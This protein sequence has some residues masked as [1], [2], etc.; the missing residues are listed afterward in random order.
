MD[1]HLLKSLF[2]LCAIVALERN[3]PET[4]LHTSD[5]IFDWNKGVAEGGVD[6]IEYNLAQNV[7]LIVDVYR[8][9]SNL[10]QN[11][12]GHL[13]LSVFLY[14]EREDVSDRI[15]THH[16][17]IAIPGRAPPQKTILW[18]RGNG[19]RDREYFQSLR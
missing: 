12:Q 11:W 3:D 17:Q 4:E 13:Q 16:T 18:C 9:M 2:E 6:R 10:I 15:S 5:I 7:Q 1:P 14:L 19:I 8:P